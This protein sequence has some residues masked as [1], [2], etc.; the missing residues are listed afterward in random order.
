MEAGPPHPS[1]LGG[2]LASQH[3]R[4]LCKLSWDFFHGAAAVDLDAAAVCFSQYGDLADAAFFNQR[5]ACGGAIQHSGDATASSGQGAKGET[6]TVDL[7]NLSSVAVIVFVI[8]AFSGGTLKEC[9]TAR[10]EIFENSQKLADIGASGPQ[11]G[12]KTGLILFSLFRH[13]DHGRW[14]VHHNFLPVYGRHFMAAMPVIRGKSA[15]QAAPR[16]V[17]PGFCARP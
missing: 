16:R 9:E 11:L 14:W 5:V 1:P 17:E 12:D 13:P 10:C 7:D 4:V 3:G 8:S 2:E 6:I 15:A